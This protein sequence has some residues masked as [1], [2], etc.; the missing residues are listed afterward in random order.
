MV[1][2][3]L[4][5]L[6]LAGAAGAQTPAAPPQPT[7]PAPGPAVPVKRGQSPSPMMRMDTH[8]IM[9]PE[10]GKRPMPAPLNGHPAPKP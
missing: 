1:R 7:P 9:M 3:Y 10:P 8:A 2:R 4:S 6:L 5:A